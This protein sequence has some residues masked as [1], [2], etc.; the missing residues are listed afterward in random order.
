MARTFERLIF[1]AAILA[2]LILVLCTNHRVTKVTNAESDKFSHIDRRI[3][4]LRKRL[5]EAKKTPVPEASEHQPEPNEPL[6]SAFDPT[7]DLQAFD[8]PTAL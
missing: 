5:D 7:D 2:L 6:P 4:T 3:T 8:A 1:F